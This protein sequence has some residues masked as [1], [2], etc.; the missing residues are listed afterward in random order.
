[1][2]RK[3]PMKMG[4]PSAYKPQ[5]AKDIITFFSKEPYHTVIVEKMKEYWKDGRLKKEV[6]KSKPM[7]NQM[8]TLFRFAEQVG[9]ST[10]TLD[11]WCK[12]HPDFL[13]AFTRAK[14]MQKEFLITL[15]LAG[16]TPPAS[17]IFVAANYSG[18]RGRG[19]MP[20]DL[21]PEAFVVPILI[22][23]QPQALPEAREIRVIPMDDK[24][25]TQRDPVTS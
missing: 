16:I 15:G 11:N 10:T 20:D 22:S 21:N 9:V 18:M 4:R 23:K 12:A 3:K 19:L 6:E 7:P 13:A 24:T 2:K 5:Y 14:E 25:T 1:M 17:F 8:P